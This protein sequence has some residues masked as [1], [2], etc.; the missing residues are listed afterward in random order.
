MRQQILQSHRVDA[1]GNPAGGTTTGVG[2]AVQ[3]QDGPLVIDGERALQ[4]GAFVEALIE[5]ALGRLNFYQESKFACAQNA[6]AIACL[7]L[8]LYHLDSRT[9]SRQARGVEGTHEV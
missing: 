4:N 2:L 9:R 7:E 6:Q 1:D 8:A 3:W 5:A